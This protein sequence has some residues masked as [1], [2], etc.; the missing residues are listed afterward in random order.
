MNNISKNIPAIAMLMM[1]VGLVLFLFSTPL[2]TIYGIYV[3]VAGAVL[4]AIVRIIALIRSQNKREITRL[5]QIQLL[6]VASLL[7]AG[8][9]MYD[10][11]NSWSVLFLVSAVL[12]LYVSY[13]QK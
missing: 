6:S 12:E 4:L 5:P 8:Y 9:L 13:R 3:F 2:N 10:G 1:T 11:S 7:G